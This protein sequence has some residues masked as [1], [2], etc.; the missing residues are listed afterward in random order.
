M[1]ELQIFQNKEFGDIRVTEVNGTPMFCLVDVCKALGLANP[2]DVKQRLN[3]KGVQLIDTHALCSTEGGNTMTN[4]ITEAN[5]YKCVFQSR[6]PDA[7]KFQDWVCEEVLPAIRK[8]GTYSVKPKS[9]W[10]LMAEMCQTMA[11]QEQINAEHERKI[12]VVEEKINA[13][14]E[15]RDEN[16]KK[17]LSLKLSDEKV[18]EP[19][20]RAQ[21]NQLARSF[22]KAKNIAVQDVWHKI[23][24][25][26]YYCYHI[27]IK[28]YK[29]EKGQSY[30]DIAEQSNFLDK[31][32]NIASQLV[33]GDE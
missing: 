23:Y 3:P 17:L 25:R 32:Y 16:G 6:K 15:E 30:L 27:S 4:F 21:V 10:E 24:E 33:R 28:S 19:T 8:T 20:L 29:K 5:L 26:L 1:Q 18:P 11:K 12:G 22:A 13:I 14:T 7:E 2:S 31:I 9:Q